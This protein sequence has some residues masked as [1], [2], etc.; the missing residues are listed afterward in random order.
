MTFTE[1]DIYVL[2]YI[3]RKDNGV[4]ESEITVIGEANA[5]RMFDIVCNLQEHDE[6]ALYKGKIV[7]AINCCVVP[8]VEIRREVK[9]K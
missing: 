3:N 8:E 5:H 9:G 6:I 4:D 7:K 1:N 2:S